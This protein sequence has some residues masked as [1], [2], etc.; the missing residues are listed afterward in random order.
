MLAAIAPQAISTTPPAV[1][2]VPPELQQ[3]LTSHMVPAHRT[4]AQAA[5]PLQLRPGGSGGQPPSLAEAVRGV[6]AAM[7]A[8]GAPAQAML[9]ALQRVKA[10]GP[11]DA[12]YMYGVLEAACGGGDAELALCWLDELSGGEWGFI[13]SLPPSATTSTTSAIMAEVAAARVATL[14]SQL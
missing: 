11:V 1:L 3:P 4:R 8:F 13:A 14:L 9:K 5:L 12:V 7:Q 6:H 2:F 10:A